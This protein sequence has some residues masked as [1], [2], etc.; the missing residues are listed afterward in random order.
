MEL[1]LLAYGI[2]GLA[3]FG[4]AFLPGNTPLYRVVCLILGAVMTAWAAKV[5]LLGGL[6]HVNAFVLLAP[7]VLLIRGGIGT[8][9]YAIARP[10]RP[11]HLPAPRPHPAARQFGGAGSYQP[12][13][14]TAYAA[15]PAAPAAGTAEPVYAAYPAA[16]AAE[17]AARS[18]VPV[19]AAYPAAP[20]AEP[21]AR[22]AVPV[23]AA[24]P[25]APAAE[26]A[27]RSAVPV[28]AAYPAAP[29]ATR[30]AEPVY[31]RAAFA[32]EPVYA[33]PMENPQFAQPM[34]PGAHAAQPAG[35]V[36][37]QSGPRV[38]E[39]VDPSAGRARHRA[40]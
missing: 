21:A 16:P 30:A 40:S 36:P 38:L 8:V 28:Y 14:P 23:Y 9:R 34:R 7:L 26:P 22:S 35:H 20:A 32:S 33:S 3:V 4:A 37:R 1:M 2:G 29:A 17:P 6:V 10:A 11:G 27:A 12:H 19:Y 24:Y 18:A 15:Y 13:P 39:S 25:A 5:V 31:A